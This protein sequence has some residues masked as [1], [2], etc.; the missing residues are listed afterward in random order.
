MNI[1]ELAEL[2]GV[3]TKAIRY[4]EQAGILPVPSRQ[5]N[6]Y[7]SYSHDTLDKLRFIRSA[8]AI[9]LALGEI[10]EIMALRDGGQVP[11]AYVLDLIRAHSEDILARITELELLKNELQQLA[12]RGAQLD[13]ADCPSSG[14]C[15]VIVPASHCASTSRQ[16]VTLD[17]SDSLFQ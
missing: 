6:G 3:S 14:V 12:E 4:Y 9:G 10:R 13:P 15:H 1:G 16:P 7:R 5:A 11:C 8:Q 17:S 2:A